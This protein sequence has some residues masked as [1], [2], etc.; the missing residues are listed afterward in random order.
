MNEKKTITI[1]VTS[2]FLVIAIIII[3][4]MGYFMYGFFQE[5]Q[6][7]LEQTNQLNSQID[8]LKNTVAS[9][10]NTMDSTENVAPNT[11]LSTN[12]TITENTSANTS[13]NQNNA[14]TNMKSIERECKAVLEEY[15]NLS[16]T[17]FSSPPYL[18]VELNLISKEES[19]HPLSKTDD[20]YIK[21][22][23]KYSD[24]KNALLEYITEDYFEENYGD[25]TL[26]NGFSTYLNTD[27]YVS[28][29]D[30]GA[31]GFT[32]HIQNMKLLSNNNNSLEYEVNYLYW[33]GTSEGA[34]KQLKATFEKSNTGYY[35]VSN[36]EY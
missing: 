3:L 35:V 29:F 26:K 19:L 15:L 9:L 34:P 33:E 20:N 23:A 1:S 22:S 12:E 31:S 16:S 36:I 24:F 32:D 5:K 17:S 2:L 25:G 27:G 28:V 13:T 30:G 6:T 11:S 18:L 4:G 21:T 7:A 14:A 8:T 10:Q